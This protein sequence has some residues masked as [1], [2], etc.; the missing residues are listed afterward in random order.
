MFFAEKRYAENFFQEI[1][2]HYANHL[3]TKNNCAK[4][5]HLVFKSTIFTLVAHLVDKLGTSNL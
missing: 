4:F 5:Q 2:C 1:F 3:S